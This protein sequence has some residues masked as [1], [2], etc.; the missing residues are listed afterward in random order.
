MSLPHSTRQCTNS[1]MHAGPRF[2]RNWLLRKGRKNKQQSHQAQ[3]ESRRKSN[4]TETQT[5]PSPPLPLPLALYF[6]SLLLVPLCPFSSV[7]FSSYFLLAFLYLHLFSF[8]SLFLFIPRPLRYRVFLSDYSW[9]YW[10]Q[11]P[12]SCFPIDI[13]S[14][15]Q[16]RGLYFLDSFLFYNKKDGQKYTNEWDIQKHMGLK[17]FF[18]P[19]SLSSKFESVK[20]SNPATAKLLKL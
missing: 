4:E 8:S 3:L 6:A 17:V 12:I 9:I 20:K 7:S 5:M 19:N 18:T 15:V 11:I 13:E 16:F 1:E 10:F 14:W 2:A